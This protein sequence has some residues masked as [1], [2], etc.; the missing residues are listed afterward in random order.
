[1]LSNA[2]GEVVTHGEDMLKRLVEQVASPVRW[3]RCMETLVHA[4]VTAVVEVT[5]AGTLT[6]LFGREHK[7][8]KGVALKAPA[9][10]EAARA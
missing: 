7:T 5:P 3:D 1:M 9:D 4:G 8:V 10:L 6:G 2:D